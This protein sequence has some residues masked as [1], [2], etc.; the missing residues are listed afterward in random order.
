MSDQLT[1]FI[2]HVGNINNTG[3]NVVVV[4]MQIPTDLTHALI[5]DTDAL[6]DHINDALR[7]LVESADAQQ[8]EVLAD[9]LA[10]RIMPD[11]SNL[12]MLQWF[13]E[14]NRL[15]KIPIS[16]VSMTPKKGV[17][18]PLSEVISALNA[19]KENQPD[20]LEDLSPEERAIALSK[21]QKF[22][23]HASNILDDNRTDKT[24]E[25]ISLLKQAELLESDVQSMRIK[26]YKLAPHLTKQ[27]NASKN[28]L[29]ELVTSASKVTDSL[30]NSTAVADTKPKRSRKKST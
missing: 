27:L 8:A 16:N 20:T 13:H 21:M 22:N 11:G 7:K 1:G 6:P 23:M 30:V 29:E 28:K 18:W 26:A 14:H 4:F 25:A 19:L 17:S 2:K 5:I 12:S 3:K 10:R 9:V 24:D 15:Q